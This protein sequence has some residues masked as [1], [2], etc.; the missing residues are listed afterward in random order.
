MKNS[1]RLVGKANPRDEAELHRNDQN[2][3]CAFFSL[4]QTGSG[5]KIWVFILNW[6]P[7]QKSDPETHP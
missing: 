7:T 3:K 6:N 2:Q 4:L 1:G 5:Q